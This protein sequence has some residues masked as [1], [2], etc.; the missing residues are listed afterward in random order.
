MFVYWA[1]ERQTEG[2]VLHNPMCVGGHMCPRNMEL[3]C[4]CVHI[5]STVEVGKVWDMSVHQESTMQGP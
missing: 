5:W 2:T 1:R 3:V 4:V